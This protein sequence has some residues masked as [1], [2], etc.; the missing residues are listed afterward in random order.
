M[1]SYGPAIAAIALIGAL[2]TS[3][4]FAQS[5]YE[6]LPR[7][8][9]T[10]IEISE[11][12]LIDSVPDFSEAAI[13]DKQRALDSVREELRNLDVDSWTVPQQVDYLLVWSKL[14]EIVFD[15]RVMKPWARDPL[16]YLDQVRSVPHAE[17]PSTEEERAALDRALQSLPQAMTNAQRNLSSAVN[18]L[19]RL[20]I[21]HLENFDG[22][23][24]G[25]P[26]R[27]DPPAGTIGWFEDL[28]ARLRAAGEDALLEACRNARRAVEGY[29]DWLVANLDE[30]DESPAIG[31]ENFDW[32]LKHVRL[33]PYTKEDL[34]VIGEREFHK[35]RFKYLAARRKNAALKEL[36]L[37]RNAE[38]HEQRTHRAERQIRE[39]VAK[40]DLLT[41]PE[42][43]PDEFETDT[44]WSERAKTD[45]HFWEEL[46]FRNALNNH[47]HASIPGHR[48]DARIRAR[49]ENPIRRSHGDS[50][51]A[52]G[53]ATYLEELFLQLGIAADNPRIR[54]LFYIALIKR[55]SRFVEI[56]L[57]TGK[58]SFDEAID[59]MIRWVPFMEED[60]GRYDLTG[61]VRRPGLGSMYIVGKHQI[62]KLASERADQL[63]D[64]FDL[65]AFHD[66]LLSRGMIP[67]TLLR[68]EMT[69]YEDEVR[70]IWE[71]VVG[72]PFPG[73][74]GP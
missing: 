35:Y 2:V 74:S 7:L 26:Y 14:N 51:R 20:T 57:H 19:A 33:L 17:V 50:A 24:Q 66:D 68:W 42:H 16:V 8:N 65:G 12:R 71:D 36:S 63:G 11:P 22:V 41:I 72:R 59:Y 28:C 6:K 60:L 64:R 1:Y 69:G 32:Y 47:I 73:A 56:D 31:G 70:K 30:M 67:V 15:H 62:E 10:I 49:L 34:R 45:R 52:E 3:A 58:R 25:E 5:D 53:W 38:Q 4:S 37:T 29:R 13:A 43:M 27:V 55:G 18:V 61:Y 54:E 9:E 48:F 39:L 46:Q 40:Y 21:F 23:G 44:F